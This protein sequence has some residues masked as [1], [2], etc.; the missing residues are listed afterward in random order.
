MQVRLST[1]GTSLRSFEYDGQQ[2]SIH[3]VADMSNLFVIIAE[4]TFNTLGL[5][6]P[7]GR[8]FSRRTA[9]FITWVSN[10]NEFSF[11]VHADYFLPFTEMIPHA[12]AASDEWLRRVREAARSESQD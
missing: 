11:N 9:G 8:V 10:R 12:R 2:Y 3:R 7:E 6:S 5:Q 1:Q 4:D